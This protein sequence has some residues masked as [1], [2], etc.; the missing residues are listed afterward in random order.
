MHEQRVE[1]NPDFIYLRD[2]MALTEKNKDRTVVS[3]NEKQRRNEQES[4][5]ASLLQLENERRKAKGLSLY[6]SYEDIDRLAGSDDEDATEGADAGE[7]ANDDEEEGDLVSFSALSRSEINPDKDPFL[8][9][10]GHILVD[11]IEQLESMDE[12]DRDRVANW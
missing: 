7:A 6:D 12:Q 3:L 5:E 1:K 9:E 2:Q 10:A 11:F 4:L 8:N